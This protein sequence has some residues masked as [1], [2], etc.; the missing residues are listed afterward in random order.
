MPPKAKFT[1]EEIID[2]A[3]A[4]VREEGMEA[5]TA[6]ELGN[7]LGSS[8]RPIFTVF[9]NMD[10]LK[11]EVIKKA[12]ELDSQ[13]TARG[14]QEEIPFKGVGKAY[15]MFAQEEPQLFRLLFMSKPKESLTVP[16]MVESFND[17]CNISDAIEGPYGMDKDDAARMFQHMWIYTH[18]IATMCVNGLCTYTPEEISDRLTEVFAALLAQMKAKKRSELKCGSRSTYGL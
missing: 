13:Y 2:A 10:E 12:I 6:R 9:T 8:A 11:D 3:F 16:S 15:I 14:L 4:L 5:L 7:R 18:G 17:V 1:K